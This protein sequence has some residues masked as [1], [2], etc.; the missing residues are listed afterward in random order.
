M[1]DSVPAFLHALRTS[2]LLDPSQLNEVKGKIAP[3]VRN[4]EALAE[5]LVRRGWLTAYQVERLF[6]GTDD[7]LVVGRYRIL[8][9]L[10]EGG[11]CQ[12]FKAWDTG[13]RWI[14]A[15]KVVHAGL[16]TQPEV[17]AQLRQ[18]VEVMARL[19]HPN[20]I[21]V[22]QAP[23]DEASYY[24]AMEYV[25]G[26]DLSKVLKHTGP[27]PMAQ[28]CDYVRQAARGLQ[29]AYEQGLVH[30]DVKPANLV[31]TYEG[32][33][34]R[35]LDIGLARLEWSYND[36]T[37]SSSSYGR[38]RPGV[39]LMGTPDYIAPEQALN[40]DQANIRADIY[41]LG[42]T[43]YHLLTGQPPFPGR[44][45]TQKLLHHQQSG[46]P[47][48]RELRPDLPPELANLVQKMMAKAPD[49]RFQTP[50]GVVVALARFCHGGPPRISLSQFRPEAAAAPGTPRESEAG[51]EE[52]SVEPAPPVQPPAPAAKP[53]EPAPA[54]VHD[55]R[56]K[57]VRRAGNPVSVEL[58]DV[59]GRSE[60]LRG[61]VLDR[62]VL[63]LGVLLD[64]PLEVG[65]VMNVLS[66]GPAGSERTFRLRI[67]YCVPQKASW[68]VGCQFLEAL[69]YGD[70]RLFG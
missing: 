46:P 43:C 42:C 60:P 4:P 41:S 25:D 40:P 36:L 29:F 52:A 54:A 55:E 64:E 14:V 59:P 65:S 57:A 12:V 66:L 3:A 44:S 6:E 13:N 45:L 31:V 62:S 32:D 61:W 53:R 35:I 47:S 15:L 1:I 24:F 7:D 17:L 8:E 28:V 16:R 19:D 50:A 34:V 10:G 2:R 38:H 48:V 37:S 26:I 58:R 67:I 49:D 5:R 68:R 63:G 9:L 18:E 56:R 39:T 70:V 23:T 30:R 21:K 51:D 27:L 33:H 20:F 69:S 22:L 11:L